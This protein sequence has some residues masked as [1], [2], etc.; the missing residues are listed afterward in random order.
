MFGVEEKVE[1]SSCAKYAA[2]SIHLHWVQYSIVMYG[3]LVPAAVGGKA[4]VV[5]V[6]SAIMGI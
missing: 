4:L 1:R 2:L 6:D 3:Y 5:M